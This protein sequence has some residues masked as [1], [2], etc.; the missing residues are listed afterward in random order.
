MINNR[1]VASRRVRAS[2]RLG[3]GTNLDYIRFGTVAKRISQVLG[4]YATDVMRV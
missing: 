4:A 1:R 2:V 3:R